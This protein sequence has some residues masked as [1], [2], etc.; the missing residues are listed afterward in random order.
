[1][2]YRKHKLSL[3]EKVPEFSRNQTL[4]IYIY[5]YIYITRLGRKPKETKLMGHESGRMKGWSNLEST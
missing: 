2:W 5:I 4:Y 3:I 1:L